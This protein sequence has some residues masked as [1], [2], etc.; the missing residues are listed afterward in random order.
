MKLTRTFRSAILNRT[1]TIERAHQTPLLRLRRNSHFLLLCVSFL[2]VNS[3]SMAKDAKEAQ[4]WPFLP[5]RRQPSGSVLIKKK[6]KS[7]RQQT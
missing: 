6:E 7:L 3:N 4:L 1:K 5:S 2:T